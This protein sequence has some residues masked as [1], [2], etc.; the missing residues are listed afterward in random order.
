MLFQRHLYAYEKA[1]HS[2]GENIH[3]AYIW[4]KQNTLLSEFINN[5]Y[6]SIVKNNNNKES[7]KNKQEEYFDRHFRKLGILLANQH[8][9]RCLTQLVMDKWKLNPQRETYFTP[10][11]MSKSKVL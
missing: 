6:N 4:Q 9:K 11:R 1:N 3:S 10:M 2:P 8:M 7:D 5:S